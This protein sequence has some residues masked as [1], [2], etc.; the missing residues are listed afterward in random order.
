VVTQPGRL[1]QGDGILAWL[2]RG[3]A[4]ART[5]GTVLDVAPTILHALGVPIAQDLDGRVADALF[6]ADALAR[7]PIRSVETYGLKGTVSR[8]RS[9]QPLDEEMLERLRSLGYVR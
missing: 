7:Y 9:G 2:G 4:T 6:E 3:S 8:P 1:H 5:T